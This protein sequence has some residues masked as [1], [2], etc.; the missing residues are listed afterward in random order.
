MSLTIQKNPDAFV[1]A[2]NPVKFVIS[3]DTVASSNHKIHV[4]ITQNVGSGYKEIGT[5]SLPVI[6]NSVSFD[7]SDY[8]Q[9]RVK[10]DFNIFD[11]F[12]KTI[13]ISNNQDLYYFYFFE[14]YD[15]DGIEHNQITHGTITAIQG[16]FSTVFLKNYIGLQKTFYTDFI[17][18]DK[19]FLTWAP[20]KKL[21]IYQHDLLYFL[22][23][24]SVSSVTLNVKYVF[25]FSDATSQT[26]YSDTVTMEPGKIH[27]F[28]PSVL[29]NEFDALET[30]LKKIVKY[31]VVV[32]ST[33]VTP[34]AYT[35]VKTYY[36]DHHTYNYTRQFI[37]KNSLGGYDMVI[38]KG[39]SESNNELQRT[40]GY[41]Q[42]KD[43][44]TY[45]DLKETFSVGSGF[46]VNQYKSLG[47]AQRY[48]SELFL[49]KEIYELVGKE[50]IP[51]IP[52]GKK[53]TIKKDG[54]FLFS[55]GFEYEYAYSDNF[56][57]PFETDQYFNPRLFY[58]NGFVDP[59]PAIPTAA[60]TV[61]FDVEIND[62]VAVDF[63]INWGDDI[64][65]TELLSEP[66][67]D[68]VSR[69]LTSEIT[70]PGGAD[71][72]RDC[73]ITDS[74]GGRYIIRYS[75]GNITIAFNDGNSMLYNDNDIITYNG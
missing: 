26:V 57:S 74:L 62:D 24:E 41:F 36:V 43:E 60:A 52:S 38:M 15:G 27:Y 1:L 2:G 46:M 51:V 45:S 59:Q 31:T 10:T 37:F 5:E 69:T 3:T 19:H 4:R 70:I 14:T 48:I 33:D 9:R 54:E 30:A 50:I 63:E 12:T 49:S 75:T 7:V 8:L 65:T 22:A 23:P 32:E 13:R 53:L 25:A 55:Y 71:G 66:F 6:N 29:A 58:S 61:S 68:G 64:G 39:F 17:Q 72:Y 42:T 28:S 18:A 21:T 56:Y 34:V 35:E 47:D 16:G 20:D 44:I 67:V 40:I 73:I 11:L